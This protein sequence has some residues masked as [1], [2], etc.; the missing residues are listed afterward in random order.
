MKPMPQTSQSQGQAIDFARVV[1]S[2]VSK[3]YE[4]YIVASM[5]ERVVMMA[6]VEN[7]HLAQMEP[8]AMQ[9]LVGSRFLS[10]LESIGGFRFAYLEQAR[11]LR[12]VGGAVPEQALQALSNAA[13]VFIDQVERK[14]PAAAAAREGLLR[15]ARFTASA[16]RTGGVDDRVVGSR[17]AQNPILVKHGVA[18]RAVELVD[19]DREAGISARMQARQSTQTISRPDRA[20]GAPRMR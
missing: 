18:Q 9:K 17:L 3:G 19:E 4:A 12:H 20:A 1:D 6:M 13:G 7:P 5:V 14:Q 8:G 15:Q 2:S 11:I 10:H 16:L